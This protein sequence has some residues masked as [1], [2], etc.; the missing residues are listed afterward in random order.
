M[1]SIKDNGIVSLGIHSK[2]HKHVLHLQ[3]SRSMNCNKRPLRK[4]IIWGTSDTKFHFVFGD[5]L[6]KQL[7]PL[8]NINVSRKVDQHW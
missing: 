5:Q 7:Y 1:T 2:R 6:P 3:Q 8:Q 4:K